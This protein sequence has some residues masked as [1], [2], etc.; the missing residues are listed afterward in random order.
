MDPPASLAV[1]PAA[2]LSASGL[3]PGFTL[4]EVLGVGERAAVYLARADGGA[5]GSWMRHGRHARDPADGPISIGVRRD[6]VLKVFAPGLGPSAAEREVL[7]ERPVAAMPV[8]LGET[9]ARDGCAVL[10]MTFCPEPSLRVRGHAAFLDGVPGAALG[11]AS[12]GDR[13][14]GAVGALVEELHRAGWAHGG[15]DDSSVLVAEDGQ[16]VLVGFS[17]ACPGGDQAFDATVL[18]DIRAV[19]ELGLDPKSAPQRAAAASGIGAGREVTA[20]GGAGRRQIEE[21]AW[22]AEAEVVGDGEEVRFLETV[23]PAFLAAR[24]SVSALRGLLGRRGRSLVRG[25]GR[26]LAV[27]AGAALIV[28]AAAWL[29]LPS[30]SDEREAGPVPSSSV[31][32]PSA[33][34]RIH[35]DAG[36]RQAATTG[37]GAPDDASNAVVAGDDPVAAA[38]ELLR[39]RA[40]CLAGGNGACL[41]DVD[42]WG[43]PAEEADRALL[44][45]A[46]GS[47]GAV[48]DGSEAGAQSAIR[49]VQRV[50]G[51]ALL[52]VTGGG[53]AKPV[54]LLVIRG[55]TGWRIRSFGGDP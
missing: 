12:D 2:S 13:S 10:V 15:I 39:V 22:D 45:D 26:R 25:R 24:E 49:L 23:E 11:N 36:E 40:A 41:S 20:G 29:T 38:G 52:E 27:G 51:V 16:V 4:L 31:A 47:H 21:W 35:I 6:V 32:E 17:Q 7:A 44:S 50:G 30:D 9:R 53:N 3:V 8:L 42:Q 19:R 33:N 28:L 55:G 14:S 54:P 37:E 48:A 5:D 1:S 34:E 18:A 46:S 43:S